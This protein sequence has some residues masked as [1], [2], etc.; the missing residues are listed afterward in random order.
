[1]RL[2]Y[3]EPFWFAGPWEFILHDDGWTISKHRVIWK[4]GKWPT[5]WIMRP[6]RKRP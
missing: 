5:Y 3:D 2:G 4:E 1:M 6:W